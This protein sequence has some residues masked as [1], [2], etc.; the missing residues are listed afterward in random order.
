MHYLR[1]QF[2]LNRKGKFL[3]KLQLIWYVEV[4]FIMYCNFGVNLVLCYIEEYVQVPTLIL[5]APT[6]EKNRLLEKYLDLETIMTNKID[7]DECSCT[8]T[9][10][11]I[12]FDYMLKL[13]YQSIMLCVLSPSV[14]VTDKAIHISH[15][16][17]VLTC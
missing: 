10:Q 7:W 12:E 6:A 14:D 13:Y 9:S 8:P 4:P 15:I 3:F 1:L 11:I 17:W 5:P 16:S 2:W